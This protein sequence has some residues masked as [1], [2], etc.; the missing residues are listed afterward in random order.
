M[1]V[2][3]HLHVFVGLYADM[4]INISLNKILKMLGFLEVIPIGR[5]MGKNKLLKFLTFHTAVNG[6]TA[7]RILGG[8]NGWRMSN[9][10]VCSL[11]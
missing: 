8:G 9:W 11:G 5:K 6:A 7:E 2:T 10:K 3:I 1:C 4:Y